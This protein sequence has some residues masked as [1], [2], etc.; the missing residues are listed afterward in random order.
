MKCCNEDKGCTEVFQL[1]NYNFHMKV[2]EFDPSRFRKCGTCNL[3]IA[4]LLKVLILKL[5][6]NLVNI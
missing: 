4:L 5:E 6:V 1:E 3:S 2:C